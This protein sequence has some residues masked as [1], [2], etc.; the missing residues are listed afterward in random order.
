VSR[1]LTRIQAVLLGLSIIGG[2]ALAGFG[3]FSVGSRQ[4]LWSDVFTL[5]AGFKQIRGVDVGTRVRVQGINAGEV[6][7]IQ[8]PTTPGGDVILLLRLDGR[9]RHLVRTDAFAQIVGE[10]LIGGKVIEIHP[11]SDSAQVV[12]DGSVIASKTAPEMA[13]VLN[14]AEAVLGQVGDVLDDVKKGEG[15]VGKLMKDGAAYGELL[16]LLKEGQGTLA[17]IRQ[18]ANAIK[19]LPIIRSYVKDAHKLLVRPDCERNR[20][21][22]GAAE[23][24][25]PGQAVL[26]ARGRAKLDQA[27][28]W[29]NGLKHSGSEVVVAAFADNSYEAQLAQTLTQKQ[30]EAVAN[31]LLN[32]HGIDKLGW[33][34]RRKVTPLGLGTNPTPMPEKE[35]LPTPRIE[36]LVFVPQG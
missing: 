33:F 22:F 32:Q 16:E 17:S 29:I 26:T 35:P 18:D 34:S 19:E 20:R 5:Q 28:P 9:V 24:F 1:S 6:T 11:G 27:A 10:G 25:E 14:R 2:L 23:L 12:K 4:L 15:S 8:Y 3:V 30:S 21:W 36:V 31:Y 7:E 13:Q